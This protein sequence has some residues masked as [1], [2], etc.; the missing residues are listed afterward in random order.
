MVYYG[1]DD[2]EL[3]NELARVLNMARRHN[4]ETGSLWVR[5]AARDKDRAPS[6]TIAESRRR[7]AAMFGCA[8]LW[9]DDQT[10]ASGRP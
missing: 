4:A 7:F 6:D 8:P 2:H 9:N 1:A 3:G 5:F 10:T